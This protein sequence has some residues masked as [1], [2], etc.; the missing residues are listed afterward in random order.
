MG[1]SANGLAHLL[2]S[3]I[4][5]H[6]QGN[7]EDTVDFFSQWHTHHL[8]AAIDASDAG[9]SAVVRGRGSEKKGRKKEK[10]GEGEGKRCR[11]L[12]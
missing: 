10:E 11:Q 2:A 7:K 4:I 6:S 3:S 5:L 1:C 8:A 12:R 9:S